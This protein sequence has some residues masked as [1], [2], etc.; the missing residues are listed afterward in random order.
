MH[1]F[2]MIYIGFWASANHTQSGVWRRFPPLCYSFTNSLEGLLF[3]SREDF[4]L[5]KSSSS[6]CGGGVAR[7]DAGSVAFA[8]MEP[9]AAAHAVQK[10]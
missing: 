2:T 7:A 3:I 9:A 4:I 10:Q 8:S 6:G 5:S 1:A